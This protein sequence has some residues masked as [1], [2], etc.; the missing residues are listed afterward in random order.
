MAVAVRVWWRDYLDQGV[1]QYAATLD[2]R[3]DGEPPRR[4]VSDDRRL[5][6]PPTRSSAKDVNSTQRPSLIPLGVNAT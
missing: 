6:S 4:T 2:E 3:A 1:P 5:T